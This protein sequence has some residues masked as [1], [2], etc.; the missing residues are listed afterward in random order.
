MASTALQQPKGVEDTL[1]TVSD[2]APNDVAVQRPVV[3]PQQSPVVKGAGER[4]NKRGAVS[5]AAATPQALSVRK[6]KEIRV[7]YTDGTYEIMYPEK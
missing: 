7:Y 2:F 1:F 6:I 3:K 5:R 4:Q